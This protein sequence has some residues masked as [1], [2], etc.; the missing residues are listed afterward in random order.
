MV[1]GVL[2]KNKPSFK[3]IINLSPRFGI[4]FI[5]RYPLISAISRGL[6]LIFQLIWGKKPLD[7]Q[8]SMFW[9]SAHMKVPPDFTYFAHIK[10]P[11]DFYY[12]LGSW[13]LFPMDLAKNLCLG[14]ENHLTV[15]FQ[16]RYLFLYSFQITAFPKSTS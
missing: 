15:T 1:I 12:F 9:S 10:V 4:T 6:Y 11:S 16:H 8:F 14:I 13:P 2:S 7:R 3:K 5:W